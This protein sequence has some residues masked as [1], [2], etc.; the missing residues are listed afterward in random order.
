GLDLLLPEPFDVE[1]IARNEMPKPLLRLRWADEPSGAAPHCI[2][3]TGA[4][5][6]LAHG[7]AAA[8][9]ARRWKH[10]GLGPLWPLL[11]HDADDLRDDVSGTLHDDRIAD[12]HVLALDLVL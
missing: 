7:M 12:A 3:L 5:V 4:R 6:H 1:G 10:E 11:F 9:R 2:W 8:D